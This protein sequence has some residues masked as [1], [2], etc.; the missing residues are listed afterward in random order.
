MYFLVFLCFY[1]YQWII[2][3]GGLLVPEG[4]IQPVFGALALTWFIH[5]RNLQFRIDKN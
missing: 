5:A 1:Y 4:V 3:A 2:S